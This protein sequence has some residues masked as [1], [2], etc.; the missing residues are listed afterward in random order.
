M[1][2]KGSEM[3]DF[4]SPFSGMEL[5]RMMTK[6]ELLSAVRFMLAA[7]LEAIQIY[8][9]VATAT[10]DPAA[11]KLIENIANEEVVHAGEFETLAAQLSPED[12][13]LIEE[14]ASEAQD[15]MGTA[16]RAAMANR[17]T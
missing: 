5:G 7:E 10:D 6:D 3:P 12:A 16:V 4:G 1:A 11:K 17:R 9:Q 13:K 2:Q 15:K 8:R 14:G